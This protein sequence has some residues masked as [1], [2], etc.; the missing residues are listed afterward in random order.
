MK[1]RGAGMFGMLL[2]CQDEGADDDG[3]RCKSSD[4]G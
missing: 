4:R 2:L 3:L 1:R